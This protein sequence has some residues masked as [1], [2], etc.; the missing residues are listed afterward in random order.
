[1]IAPESSFEKIRRGRIASA[2]ARRDRPR[3]ISSD[4][5]S[6]AID[7][8]V[9]RSALD[10]VAGCRSVSTAR[11]VRWAFSVST[12]HPLRPQVFRIGPCSI[13]RLRQVE[14]R[15]NGMRAFRLRYRLGND[16]DRKPNDG[17][18]PTRT[19]CDDAPS[20]SD[21]ARLGR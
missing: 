16:A 9:V 2:N 20:F 15:V 10:E 18:T 7:N 14:P 8:P 12:R 4:P 13:L 21:R 5:F 3:R 19:P 6:F 17:C 11:S 1:M